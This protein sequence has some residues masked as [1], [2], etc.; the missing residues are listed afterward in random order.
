MNQTDIPGFPGDR[1]NC[2]ESRRRLGMMGAND[3]EQAIIDQLPAGADAKAA[4]GPSGPID[5]L[6]RAGRELAFYAYVLG[7]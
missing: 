1:G 5:D 6:D 2:R 7:R 3:A 4:I